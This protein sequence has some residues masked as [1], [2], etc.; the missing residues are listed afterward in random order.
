[1]IKSFT[2]FA[3]QRS[4]TNY[5]EHLIT[6]NFKNIHC[7]LPMNEYAWKHEPS[8]KRIYGNYKEHRKELRQHLHLLVTKYVY[9]WIESIQRNAVDIVIRRPELLDISYYFNILLILS[10]PGK[11]KAV[12]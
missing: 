4:G 3:P 1:M 5:T 9:K 8:A 11:E 7:H 10:L 12:F 6:Q 2:V